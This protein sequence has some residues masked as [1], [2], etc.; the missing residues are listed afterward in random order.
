MY[1]DLW[2]NEGFSLEELLNEETGEQLVSES[3]RL[4]P[5]MVARVKGQ[6][7]VVRYQGIDKKGVAIFK[8]SSGTFKGKW[9][10]CRVKFKDRSTFIREAQSASY[11]KQLSLAQSMLKGDVQ[12][13]CNGDWFRYACRYTAYKS[14]YGIVREMRPARIRNPHNNKWICKHLCAVMAVLPFMSAKILAD[15]KRM[16]LIQRQNVEIAASDVFNSDGTRKE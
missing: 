10:M 9:W 1:K 11:W 14:G 6:K 7:L 2:S 13:D 15:Y 16:G 12:V 3:K 5:E 8:V 4:K